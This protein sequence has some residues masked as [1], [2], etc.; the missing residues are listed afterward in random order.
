MEHRDLSL[1]RFDIVSR[2][3]ASDNAIYWNRSQLLMVANTALLGFFASQLA[4]VSA[5]PQNLRVY[6][7]L[8]LD[9]LAAEAIVGVCLCVLWHFAITGGQYWLAQWEAILRELEPA[10][11]GHTLMFRRFDE[12]RP[13][14]TFA[15]RILQLAKFWKNPD[16]RRP[17]VRTRAIARLVQIVFLFLWVISILLVAR[18]ATRKHQLEAVAPTHTQSVGP[19]ARTCE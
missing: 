3:L 7:W 8:M 17:R 18:L 11:M 2:Y 15:R 10:A 5:D 14:K 16:A 4:G 12:S 9:Y 1:R 19:Q 6:S 13:K